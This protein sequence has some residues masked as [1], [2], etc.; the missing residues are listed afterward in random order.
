MTSNVTAI[1]WF[2]KAH[3]L[4]DN[5]AL[6]YALEN[7]SKVY[8]IF[9]LDPWFVKNYKVGPNRWRFLQQSLQD[10]N[11]RLERKKSRL[12]VLRGPALDVLEQYMTKWKVNLLCYEN[13]TEPYSR[14]RD[15]Q[16]GELA[17]RLEVR[18]ETRWTH[19]LYD[20]NYLLKRNGNKVT[21]TYVSMG[22]LLS[23]IGDPDRPVAE[24]AHDFPSLTG[25]VEPGAHPVPTLHELGVDEKDCGPLLYPGGESEALRRL[26]ESMKNENWVAK[27]E[28]PMTSPNS[29][30]PSTTVLS[31]YLK[32][33]NLS[34]R[35]F[36][37]RLK[38]IYKN[39]PNYSR[40][41][42]SLEGQLLWREFFY[43][44]GA[45]T[46]NFDK[47]VDNPICRQIN[48]DNNEEFFQAW[49]QARTGYPFIDAI[50]TQVSELNSKF[51]S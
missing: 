7:S 29:L 15:A 36:Y 51:K 50:M 37:F 22:A 25:L 1:Y 12:I 33:G 42:V 17:K 11:E 28:K 34:P 32:F 5:P 26:K 21:Y 16:V 2:R 13:D 24:Y 43:F 40:P 30:K 10:L 9:I 8:P 18:V 27:F 38:E 44:T 49:R 14:V 48:W 39:K 31:P 4:H 19:T 20:P 35:L 23:K 47:I 41:P 3:R 46:D 6:N 45:F